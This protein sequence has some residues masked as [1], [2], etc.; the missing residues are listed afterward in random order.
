VQFS[1][2]ATPPLFTMGEK[3]RPVN[4][5]QWKAGWELDLARVR[6]V[7]DL[8][9]F[10]PDDQYGYTDAPSADAYI[11]G[12]AAGNPMAMPSRMSAGEMLTAEGFGT[13]A[14][15]GSDGKLGASGKYAAGRWELV[16]T[17]PLSA[18]CPGELP[19]VPGASVSLAA[20]VWDGAVKDRNGQKSVTVWHVLELEK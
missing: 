19:L 8:Y 17:R 1:R 15:I 3:G 5:W 10:T 18:C 7:A 11:T 20:A 9:P 16:F 2:E 13:L 12:R 14:P 6:D 4:L